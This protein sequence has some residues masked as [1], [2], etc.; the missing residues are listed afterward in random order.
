LRVRGF[1]HKEFVNHSSVLLQTGSTLNFTIGYSVRNDC[2]GMGRIEDDAGIEAVV[3]QTLINIEQVGW[4][5]KGVFLGKP[6]AETF[7]ITAE[8]QFAVNYLQGVNSLFERDTNGLKVVV[9]RWDDSSI[10]G[11]SSNKHIS[12]MT[13][14]LVIGQE[15]RSKDDL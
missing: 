12:V 5:E 2:W 1:S 8:H 3:S 6:G 15:V 9:R 4:E 10:W 14:G 7:G 13:R 11:H